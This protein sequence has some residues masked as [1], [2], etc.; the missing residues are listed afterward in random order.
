MCGSSGRV[1][2]H[3]REPG[4]VEFYR[5]THTHHDSSFVQEF[6]DIMVGQLR[7]LQSVMVSPHHLQSAV[8]LRPRC[9]LN[10]WD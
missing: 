3:G 1:E 8:M 5:M 6:R 10:L 7:L 9:S 4:E 2:E